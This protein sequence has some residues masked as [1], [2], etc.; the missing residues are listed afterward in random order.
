M[1]HQSEQIKEFRKQLARGMIQPAYKELLGYIMGLRTH[2]Q[3]KYPEF[4]VPG[5]VYAGYLDMTYF[6]LVP[7]SFKERCLKIAVVFNYAAF[8]FEVWL[9]AVNRQVLA[10]YFKLFMESGWNRYPIV[11]PSENPDAVIVHVLEDDPDFDRPDE[12]TERIE[13]EV[14][15]FI[16]DLEEF[17]GAHRRIEIK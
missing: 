13:T 3:K 15:K 11:G 17:L 16:A 10:Q 6:A 1:A 5:G 9:S 14:Q 8:R 2:F 7:S 12:L 4:G